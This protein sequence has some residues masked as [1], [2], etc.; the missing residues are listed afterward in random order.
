MCDLV[1]TQRMPIQGFQSLLV[2]GPTGSRPDDDSIEH[3]KSQ[4][5][6]LTLV[7]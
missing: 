1:V 3:N 4:S 5:G 7:A 2:L 6:A